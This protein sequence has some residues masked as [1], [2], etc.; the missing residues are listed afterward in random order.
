MQTGKTASYP[1]CMHPSIHPASNTCMHRYTYIHIYIHIP[2][3][4]SPRT[5]PTGTRDRD[6]LVPLPK[7]PQPRSSRPVT[8][9]KLSYHA[10][11]CIHSLLHSTTLH[12]TPPTLTSKLETNGTTHLYSTFPKPSQT[13][14]GTT[15]PNKEN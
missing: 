2:P 12:H 6:V 14:K 3:T 1:S 5:H 4:W 7:I 15:K 13:P 10:M 11:T 8:H 9:T